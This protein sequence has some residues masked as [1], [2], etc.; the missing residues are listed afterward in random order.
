M[1]AMRIS[2]GK[3]RYRRE[4]DDDCMSQSLPVTGMGVT[5]V[6]SLLDYVSSYGQ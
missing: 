3:V 4:D 1:V 2:L 6:Y 5:I